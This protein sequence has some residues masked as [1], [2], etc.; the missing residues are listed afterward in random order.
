MKLNSDL[1]VLHYYNYISLFSYYCS[2]NL[3]KH[4]AFRGMVVD[5]AYTLEIGINERRAKEL[6]ASFLHVC[7]YS[8]GK[9]ILSQSLPIEVTLVYVGLSIREPPKI[10]V[11]TAELLLNLH[12]ALGIGDNGLYLPSGLYHARVLHC[13]VD[14]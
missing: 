14:V 11:K 13:P 7:C 9:V 4:P 3:F 1:S 2:T 12:E 8:I 5:D 6:E 10:I